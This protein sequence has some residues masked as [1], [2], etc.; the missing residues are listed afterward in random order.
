M[1]HRLAAVPSVRYRASL[2]TQKE[3][4]L[5]AVLWRSPEGIPLGQSRFFFLI[6]RL[7]Q[8]DPFGTSVGT[9][10]RTSLAMTTMFLEMPL[11]EPFKGYSR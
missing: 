8:G 1:P 7:S 10:K 9:L 2:K 11:T 4:S 3:L 6:E 5:R